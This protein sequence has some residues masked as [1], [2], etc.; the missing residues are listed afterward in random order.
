MDR[1]SWTL[2]AVVMGVAVAP[3]VPGGLGDGLLLL[4]GAVGLG[5]LGRAHRVTSTFATL[6]VAV[7]IG[8]VASRSVPEGPMLEGPV[9]FV[10]VRVGASLGR[11]GDVALARPEGGLGGRVRVRFRERAPSAGT[12]VAVFGHAGP[13]RSVLPGAPDPVRAARLS[14]IRTEVR[15]IRATVLPPRLPRRAVDDPTGML[16]A[17]VTGERRH[18][19]PAL[20]SRLRRTGTAHLLAISGF[21]VSV[22]AGLLAG[23]A[24]VAHRAAAVRWPGGA[25]P[26]GPGAVGIVA[27]LTYAEH[28]GAPLSAQRATLVLALVITGRLLGRQPRLP[29]ILATVAATVAVVDPSGIATPGFQL[30]FGAVAGIAAFAPRLEGLLPPEAPR[31]V[32]WVVRSL[33]ASVGA[34][35]GTLPAAAWWFQQ[36]APLSPLANLVAVP[37]VGMVVV[38]C[39]ALAHVLPG[40]GSGL[41][42]HVGTFAVHG[43]FAVLAPFDVEPWSPAVG[44]LGAVGLAGLLVLAAGWWLPPGPHWRPLGRASP[45]V[46]G[47]AGLALVAGPPAPVGGWRF[48]FLDVGQGDALYIEHPSGSRWLVDGGPPSRAVLHW[49]RRHGVRHLDVVVVTHRDRDHLGG[50]LPVIDELSVGEVWT[51]GAPAVL[52][53]ACA[54]A[55]VPLQAPPTAWWPPEGPLPPGNDASVVLSV[56]PVLMLGDVSGEVEQRLVQAGIGRHTVLKVAHHGSGTST[57]EAL[58]AAVQPEH[59]V[60]GVGGGNRYGHPAPGV[61]SRLARSGVQVWRTDRDGTV[62]VTFGVG[63]PSHAGGSRLLTVRRSA[64]TAPQRGIVDP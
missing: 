16:R 44:P 46:G 26:W 33:A 5:L 61:L 34:T 19:E 27:A 40:P 63:P 57:S 13:V 29:A 42:A 43:L 22:V 24:L 12:A 11:S 15:V 55:G 1:L 21:H 4:L 3:S 60:I 59:A 58:L 48:V 14:G 49:L 53:A 9:Q 20:V 23:L 50:T 56:G 41:A 38:P 32:R 35:L 37:L 30:S 17:L 7:A 36:L 51:R 54:R 25:V 28:A 10:G 45:L 6:G 8:L 31:G 52:V 62:V 39:A 18:L 47:L 2:L 64:T